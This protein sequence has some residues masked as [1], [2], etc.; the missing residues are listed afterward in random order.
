MR[1]ETENAASIGRGQNMR[2]AANRSQ[3]RS[4]PETGMTS[5]EPRAE[6]GAAMRAVHAGR[7]CPWRQNVHGLIG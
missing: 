4:Q 6:E 5:I 7:P 2:L 1:I 3:Q